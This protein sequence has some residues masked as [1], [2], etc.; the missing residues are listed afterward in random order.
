MSHHHHSYDIKI[1]HSYPVLAC[2]GVPRQQG[3]KKGRGFSS[4]CHTQRSKSWH[5]SLQVP[6]HRGWH[7]PKP[8]P[9]SDEIFDPPSPPTIHPRYSHFFIF[10]IKAAGPDQILLCQ[11]CTGNENVFSSKV[12]VEGLWRTGRVSCSI[13]MITSKA[14][15]MK[16]IGKE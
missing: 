15:L 14:K 5:L 16:H 6:A 3:L 4:P 13:H 2:L 8:P 7:S 1:Q 10:E 9:G 11:G 12:S